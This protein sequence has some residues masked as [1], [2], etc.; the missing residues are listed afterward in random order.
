M[1]KQLLFIIQSE[2]NEWD[3]Q[4]KKTKELLYLDQNEK[5]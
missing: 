4:D 1:K 2:R 3:R 5:L